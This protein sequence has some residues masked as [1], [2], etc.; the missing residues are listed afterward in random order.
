MGGQRKRRGRWEGGRKVV[1]VVVVVGGGIVPLTASVC[2]YISASVQRPQ[3]AEPVAMHA[4]HGPVDRRRVLP[5]Q[6]IAF[7]VEGDSCT[8]SR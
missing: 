1:V 7:S 3:T 2:V 5:S 6:C 8:C 4:S